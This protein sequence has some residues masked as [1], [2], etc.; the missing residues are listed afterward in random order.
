MQF[1]LIGYSIRMPILNT[2]LIPQRNF[3]NSVNCPWKSMAFFYLY[4]LHTKAIITNCTSRSPTAANT[5]ATFKDHF[6]DCVPL[7]EA[8]GAADHRGVH[9]RATQHNTTPHHLLA[10]RCGRIW[11]E[12]FTTELAAPTQHPHP[13]PHPHL[14]VLPEDRTLR[15]AHLIKP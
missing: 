6:C 3:P 2:I 13:Y 11:R 1:C 14:S 8:E 15:S 12:F 4:W 9:T 10:F 5:P 7:A